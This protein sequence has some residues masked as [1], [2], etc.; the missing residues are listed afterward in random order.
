MLTK[1]N[2]KE[3]REIDKTKAKTM[4]QNFDKILQIPEKFY[5]PDYLRS[6]GNSAQPIKKDKMYIKTFSKA[7]NETVDKHYSHRVED[8][9]D[10]FDEQ[11]R[12][13]VL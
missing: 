5:N 12:R 11:V 10:S 1:I 7:I 2:G 9:I 3:I 13:P 6:L 4:F 8:I